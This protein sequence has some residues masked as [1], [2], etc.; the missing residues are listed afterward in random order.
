MSRTAT[1]VGCHTWIL[2]LVMTRANNRIFA[3]QEK[4]DGLILLPPFPKKYILT[5]DDVRVIGKQTTSETKTKPCRE[6]VYS[7]KYDVL[8][9]LR[10]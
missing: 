7:Y 1:L 8:I 5:A 9:I 6:T 10:A 2:L 3:F 4:S